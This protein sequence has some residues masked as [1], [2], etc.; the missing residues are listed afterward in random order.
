MRR[1]I[2]D[3]PDFAI[4]QDD[5]DRAL[6]YRDGAKRVLDL[7]GVLALAPIALPLVGGLWLLARRDGGPGFFGHDRVG[8]GGQ[9]FRCWKIRTMGPDAPARLAAYLADNPAAMRE[10]HTQYKLRD[11]P[12]VTPLGRVLRKT[13]LDELPQLWNVLRGEM[14]LVGPRPVPRA[15]L[16]AY[17]GFARAYL[18]F[19]PGITGLWQVSG[20]N[21]VAYAD[22]VRMDADYARRACLR[23]DLAILWRTIGVVLRRTGL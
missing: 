21:D 4:R 10:W 5:R 23:V 17:Q 16:L 15:E 11:D 2:F 20:R 22:R 7:F 13:S 9:V 8:R 12:R 1:D 14:S 18:L 3:I 19:R 6:R